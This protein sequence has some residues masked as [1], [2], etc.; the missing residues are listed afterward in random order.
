MITRIWHGYTSPQNADRYETIVKNEVIPG[1]FEM[2]IPGFKRIELFRRARET[3]VE[4]ITAM[5]FEDLDAVKAFVG[6]DYERAHVPPRAR[7]VLAD[8]DERSQHYQVLLAR[9]SAGSQA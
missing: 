8:F 5:W 6:E 3:D 4:F 9:D 1:I 7:Q 2:N